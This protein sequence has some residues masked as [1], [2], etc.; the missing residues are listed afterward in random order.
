[1]FRDREELPTSADLGGAID[2]ALRAS[3]YLVVICSPAAARSIWVNAEVRAFK[4][5]GRADRIMCLVV[6]GEPNAT[7][8]GRAELECFC[9]A[10][11]HELDAAG[12][13]GA[14]RVE[15]LAADVS[16]A[17]G[18]GIGRWLALL[19]PRIGIDLRQ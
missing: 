9:P 14:V 1:M 10:L 2:A 6:D 18:N 16:A 11:R 15:P 7:D 3:R 17:L 8:R 4:R 5:M 13:I 12:E 19:L